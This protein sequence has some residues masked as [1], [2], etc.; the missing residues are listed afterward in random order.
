MP[1]K[2]IS[3]KLRMRV[4]GRSKIPP[5]ETTVPLQAA[6]AKA[7]PQT[8]IGEGF[9]TL[10]V[11][12][13]NRPT[14]TLILGT[15]FQRTAMYWQFVL[16]NRI[17]W[18][19]DGQAPAFVVTKSVEDLKAIGFDAKRLAE[20]A[21][22]GVVEIE[23]PYTV[24]SVG[25]EFRI[26][27]WE[28]LLGTAT[29]EQRRGSTLNVVRNIRSKTSKVAAPHSPRKAMVVESAPGILGE[30]YSFESEQKLVHANLALE[31]VKCP[32]NPTVEELRKTIADRR[33]DV[34]HL[35][36]FDSHQGIREIAESDPDEAARIGGPNSDPLMA[37]GEHEW[38]G[39]IMAKSTGT[40]EVVIDQRLASAIS[41]AGK[42][43]PLLVSCNF[44][45]SGPRVAA[46]IAAESAHASIGFQDEVD[47]RAAEEFFANFY[48]A[49]RALKWDLLQ[50]FRVALNATP[51]GGAV[52]VLWSARSLLTRVSKKPLHDVRQAVLATR[53]KPPSVD[54]SKF[55]SREVLDIVI[56]IKDT[57]NY[58]LLQNNADLFDQFTIRK[59]KGGVIRDVAVEVTLYVG[60]E[61]SPYYCTFDIE[62]PLVNLADKIRFTLT[63]AL[64]R[65]IR[66][67]VNTVIS[68]KVSWNGKICRHDTQ[69]IKLLAIDE[70][71][72]TPELDAYLPSFVFPRDRAVARV[73]DSAQRYLM[74][75]NDDSNAGFDGYQNSDYSKQ[76]FETVHLQA[77]AIWSALSYDLPLSYINPPPTFTESSQ[78]L[79]TPTD[80]IEGRRGTCIDLALL[81]AACLE[82]IG[83]YPVLFLLTDH[84]FPGYWRSEE[85]PAEFIQAK[86]TPD[87][88]TGELRSLDTRDTP[89]PKNSW[90]FNNYKEVVE[91]TRRGSLVPI[92][93]VW[94]TQH[95]GF[96]EAVD[97]G[98]N[99]LRSKREFAMMIDVQ[100]A[101]SA[102]PPV[103]PLPI[104]KA[105]S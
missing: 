75:L 98:M 97:E 88:R 95:E 100:A 27:P 105:E 57:L 48:S 86:T 47:D 34:I 11:R 9:T 79:R 7:P 8:T 77:L 33:P 74:A 44:Y 72:D 23:I 29:S 40:P 99:D 65:S 64:I 56:K 37:N 30:E 54:L 90:Y 69:P 68:V 32:T 101:R 94:P 26:F 25:W 13:L 41:G 55:D 38:D 85:E 89:M 10:T 28:F 39:Y 31:E 76:D 50:A 5:V 61:N 87:Q 49:W 24:E 104:L 103:T 59:L 1:K 52:I 3:S 22:S 14:Y 4:R 21:D 35:A 60:T 58:S 36:G 78:R 82:Y 17:R 2:A 73:I 63:S 93:T 62:Q 42:H 51:M 15:E 80:V 71:V 6:A 53:T 84:S 20:I 70:W 46:M 43:L 91:L 18:L 45:N 92:E 96:W 102:H 67:S 19:R 12:V 66:E 16:S 81:L 83:I